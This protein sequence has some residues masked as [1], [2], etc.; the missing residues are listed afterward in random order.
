MIKAKKKYGQNFLK[1]QD[2]ISKIIEAIPNNKNKIVEIGP[3]LGDLTKFIVKRKDVIA[4]EVDSELYEYLYSEFKDEIKKVN[5][6]IPNTVFI[7]QPIVIDN[8]K[9]YLMRLWFVAIATSVDDYLYPAEIVI[10]PFC[11]VVSATGL[12]ATVVSFTVR[13]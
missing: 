11:V 2:A 1:D 9:M 13:V 5:E 3:G 6:V 4:Y 12:P 7:F 10:S 8:Y